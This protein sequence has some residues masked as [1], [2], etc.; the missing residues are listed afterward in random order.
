MSASKSL[1]EFFAQA[2]TVTLDTCAKEAIHLCGHVQQGCAL[3]AICTDSGLI[4]AASENATSFFLSEVDSLLGAQ[5]C[6]LDPELDEL[7]AEAVD[8]TN[9]HEVLEYAFVKDGVDYDVI[10]HVQ[11]NQR[12]IEFLPN[13]A[14]SPK[15][16]RSNMRHCSKSCARIL[17]VDDMGEAYK[18]AAQASRKITGYA[19]VNVYR[20]LP[21]WSGE[22]LAESLA[23]EGLQSYLGLHF[24]ASDIPAQV[25]EIMHIVPYRAIGDVADRN[26]AILQT[27]GAA[28]LDLTWSAARSVSKM[29]TQYLRNMGVQATFCVSLMLHGKLWGIIAAHNPDPGV[30]PFDSW[31][32]IH[33]I[34]AALMLKFDQVERLQSAAK[35]SSLRKIENRFASALRHEN[36]LEGVIETLIPNLRAFLKADGFAFQYGPTMYMC[37]ETPPEDTVRE[38]ILWA[39]NRQ[40][41]TDQYQTTALYRDWPPGAD[42]IDSACGV[43]IQPIV[44]HRVC[45]LIWFRGPVT[46]NVKWAGQPQKSGPHGDLSPRHSFDVWEQEHRDKALPWEEADLNSAR[47][48]FTEFLDILAAHLLL[49]EE[50]VYLRHFAASAVHDI[51]APLRGISAALDIMREENFDE[52]I[53]KETHS[54]AECSAKRLM[55]LSSGLLEL[56]AISDTQTSFTPTVLEIVIKDACTMLAHDI[57]S[58][59]AQISVA[60]PHIINANEQL[61]LRLFLNLIQNALKYRDPNRALSISIDVA[62]ETEDYI[63]IAITDTGVGISSKYAERIF[64]PLMRL[65]GQSEI[66]GAGLGLPICARIAEAHDGKI[67]VDDA[68]QDG[69]RFVIR[70]PS[71]PQPAVLH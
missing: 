23:S 12:L 19:R 68:Y 35:I 48:V 16:T 14:A 2:E 5:L 65:H 17:N 67:Y 42:H 63:E 70:L 1:A 8:D 7:V 30:V 4:T 45:Q 26:L 25:R 22:V 71:P 66:E 49:K 29:H 33:E 64:K 58:E 39:Q 18:I 21:D 27:S 47:E 52:S 43:L 40:N 13:Y 15:T 34:G 50:N 6:D 54:M 9:M 57:Q 59:D 55:N 62:R 31:T 60:V 3:L 38:L 69:A 61:L 37:G 53:V 46:R 24:P 56:A 44:V 36:D 51:K 32:L 11:D 41:E 20:F 28:P 10:T